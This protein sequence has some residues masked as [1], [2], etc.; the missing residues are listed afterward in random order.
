MSEQRKNVWI[1]P[2][3]TGLLVRIGAY[4]LLYQVIAWVFFALCDYIN[5]AI[6]FI[7]ADAP[8]FSTVL[9]RT[10]MTLLV[11]VPILALDAVRFAHRLV[12]PL[13]R[14][15]KTIQAV[16][17]GEP[18]TLVQLRRGDLLV[19]LQDDFNE[20]LITLQQQGLVLLKAPGGAPVN[21]ETP[22]AVASTPAAAAHPGS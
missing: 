15:R 3:Q 14:V 20:M 21:A 5:A 19:E 8:F 16:A 13:Y 22:Q 10:L 4:C 17:A 11:L 2:F 12:G 1:H 6:A 18:V 7:G 9:G